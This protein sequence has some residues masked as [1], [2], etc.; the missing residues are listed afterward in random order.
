MRK[1]RKQLGKE[2]YKIEAERP[3]VLRLAGGEVL[4]LKE[5]SLTTTPATMKADSDGSAIIEAA[6]NKNLAEVNA[7]PHGHRQQPP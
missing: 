5:S 6:M 3:R 1:I 2:L 7:H 4:N